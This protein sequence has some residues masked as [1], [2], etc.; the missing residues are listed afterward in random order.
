MP[1]MNPKHKKST[2]LPS[3]IAT[4]GKGK[5]PN[6]KRDLGKECSVEGCSA[7]AVHAL[8]IIEY[9]SSLKK[10]DIT[11][12]DL[13]GAR[14]FNICKEHYKKMKVQK[15]KEDK[16]LKPKGDFVN[17]RFQKKDKISGM[18]DI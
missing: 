12:K 3:N 5:L 18:N 6:A 9:E 17:Q 8:S 16:I 10:A 1:K 7:E 4:L 13:Q 2:G 15:K 11:L 14:K